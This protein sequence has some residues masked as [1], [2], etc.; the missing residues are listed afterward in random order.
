MHYTPRAAPHHK[1]RAAGGASPV[2][3]AGAQATRPLPALGLYADKYVYTMLLSNYL[4][5]GS[6]P[7][8]DKAK[9]TYCKFIHAYYV[10]AVFG[11]CKGKLKKW[12]DSCIVMGAPVFDP[13]HDAD[14][15]DDEPEVDAANE[16]TTAEPAESL[17]V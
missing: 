3:A 11:I 15:P 1:A 17:S 10:K 5:G 6:K 13:D 8:F 12:V 9:Y 7:H 16:S 2:E 4:F 14:A